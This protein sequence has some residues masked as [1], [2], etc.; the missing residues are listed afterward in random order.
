MDC[1]AAGDVCVVTSASVGLR[2]AIEKVPIP[3]RNVV[4]QGFS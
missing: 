2:V 3:E 1:P 4:P